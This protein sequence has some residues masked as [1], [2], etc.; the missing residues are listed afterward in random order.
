MFSLDIPVETAGKR[1]YRIEK[2]AHLS[3]AAR[4]NIAETAWRV[5]SRLRNTLLSLF[6]AAETKRILGEQ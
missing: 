4:M 6:F 1:G 5:R 3:T 2:A